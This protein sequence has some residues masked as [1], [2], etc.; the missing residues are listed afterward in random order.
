MQT[1]V[2]VSIWH[3][4]RSSTK[5]SQFKNNKTKTIKIKSC[6]TDRNRLTNVY[7]DVKRSYFIA[8]KE[9]CS[10]KAKILIIIKL[11]FIVF[12]MPL[13]FV[14]VLEYN[15]QGYIVCRYCLYIFNWMK[16][17]VIFVVMVTHMWYIHAIERADIKTKKAGE[18]HHIL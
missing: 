2:S 17:K 4:L 7:S 14:K 3:C 16:K 6:R 9:C 15:K 1:S 11:G 5:V 8:P 10:K 13:V 12:V 18:S